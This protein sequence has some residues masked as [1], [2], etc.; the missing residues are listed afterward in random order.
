MESENLWFDLEGERG[1]KIFLK[2]NKNLKSRIRTG[3][4]SGELLVWNDF[5]L[6]I[7]TWQSG[8]RN[9]L[10]MESKNLW[11]D[12]EGERG[13]KIFEKKIKIWNHEFALAW[14]LQSFWFK[15]ISL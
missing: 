5:A 7:T 4:K 13:E 14:N 8:Q 12:L 10:S 15:M 6:S 11:F 2:K 1:E 9:L 3:V